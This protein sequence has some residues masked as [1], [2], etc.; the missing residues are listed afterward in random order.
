MYINARAFNRPE[1]SFL[2]DKCTIQVQTCLVCIILSFRNLPSVWRK[3][4][5]SL[6]Q[7]S[8][9]DIKQTN[10]ESNHNF[11][12]KCNTQA[13]SFARARDD[14]L[15][16]RGFIPFSWLNLLFHFFSPDINNLVLLNVWSVK[17]ESSMN[18]LV[19]PKAFQR[20]SHHVSPEH[21]L[22]NI[23]SNLC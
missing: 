9:K 11:R 18:I 4:K 10:S 1:L 12:H 14:K 15:E 19:H 8:V 21:A 7:A 2:T 5:T 13:M 23:Q 17:M 20:A 22:S 6:L 16:N 3:H